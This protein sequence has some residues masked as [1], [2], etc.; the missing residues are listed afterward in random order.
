MA[1]LVEKHVEDALFN[2]HVLGEQNDGVQ[3]FVEMG[4]MAGGP[5]VGGPAISGDGAIYRG[6]RSETVNPHLFQDFPDG[7]R[8]TLDLA[9]YPR[10]GLA[11]VALD[12]FH[13]A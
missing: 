5:A 3:L 9:F 11:A 10:L 13:D 7:G 6:I 4:G 2:V 8:D 12:H 1:H